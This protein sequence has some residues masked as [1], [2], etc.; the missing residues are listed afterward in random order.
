MSSYVEQTPCDNMQPHQGISLRSYQ[1][2]QSFLNLSRSQHGAVMRSHYGSCSG[3]TLIEMLL[4][5]VIV[6]FLV[7]LGAPSYSHLIKNNQLSTQSN[8]LL[9]ALSY[10]RSEA[11]TQ[12]IKVGICPSLSKT[13]CDS[14]DWNENWLIFS[15]LNLNGQLDS[16]DQI[17]RQFTLIDSEHQ[18]QSRSN[19]S[20]IMY[21]SEGLTGMT[22]EFNLCSNDN[23][24]LSKKVIVNSI[25]RPKVVEDN[26]QCN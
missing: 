8:Q 13:S 11:I 2:K 23:N 21:T 18:W 5:T 25:G 17:L 16:D 20:L 19:S 22:E 9:V 10:A 15:D 12:N 4:T 24:L 3:L 14:N 7:L 6:A 26:V 1:K